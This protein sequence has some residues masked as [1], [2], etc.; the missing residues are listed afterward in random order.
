MEKLRKM[1][2]NEILK[3]PNVQKLVSDIDEMVEIL[4]RIEKKLDKIVK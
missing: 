4:K 3:N 2:E 1:A